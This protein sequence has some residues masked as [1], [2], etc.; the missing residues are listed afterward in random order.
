MLFEKVHI[1]IIWLMFCNV[2]STLNWESRQEF[3]DTESAKMDLMQLDGE[4]IDNLMNY[5]NKM[6]EKASQLKRL[7]RDID[8]T[9]HYSNNTIFSITD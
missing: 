3:L 7:A 9:Y 2:E 6:D 8:V 5:A 1:L 4:L